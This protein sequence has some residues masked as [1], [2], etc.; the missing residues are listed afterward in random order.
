MHSLPRQ[1]IV[2][3]FL[4]FFAAAAVAAESTPTPTQLPRL[5]R[6]THYN[7]TIEPDAA[8]LTF[9]GDVAISLEVLAP[10][11]SITLNA[12]DMKFAIGSF[13]RQH[14][15]SAVASE[16]KIT[17]DEAA[18]TAT[19]AFDKK[20]PS[21]SYWL[22][23]DYTGKIGTQAV[24]L[25]AIDYDT[26]DRQEARAVHAVRSVG[27]AP[28]DPVLG[29]AGLQGDVRARSD[30]AAGPDG[31]QQ[32][33][34]RGAHRHGR[35]PR[36][37]ALRSR[38]RRCRPTC[39]S[40]G[41]AN[42]I[43]RPRS[44]D[45][46]E[47]GVVTQKGKARPGAVRARFAPCSVLREYNDYFGMPYPLPKLDNIA[48]PGSSQFFG[49]M[50]NWG[51]IFTFEYAMLLDPAISTQADKQGVFGIAAHE[52][53]HQ[54]FGDLVTMRWWDDLWLNEGFASWM[55]S[56]TTQRLHP[57]W[58]AELQRREL[59]RA[60][61]AIATR[62]R[63]P[64]R[65]CSRVETVEQAAQAFD[66]ISYS[67]G[68]AVMH[69]LE[70]YVGDD[71]WR[72][73]VRRYMKAHAYGNTVSDDL[74]REVEAAA[75]QPITAIAHDFTL[76]PGVPLIRVASATCQSGQTTLQ[77]AQGEFSKRPAEQEAAGVAR[78]RH[79]RSR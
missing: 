71:A 9:R 72:E 46:T 76:Q 57:E 28:H 41:S 4:A 53:A 49:A 78:A 48:S 30:R 7:V 32:H 3:T 56:R 38:R 27:C 74:W 60:G 68:Q 36:A 69:M 50:E 26:A 59:A 54:W 39:C 67:K 75:G 21:G 25:F 43:A 64:T 66:A 18:Q 70:G 1:A 33:A 8:A 55:A 12:L 13:H 24:G 23:L 40:S 19:F 42:S 14:R 51:A 37:R 47:L 22:A 58:H 34:G 15:Q 52:I 5:V 62:S 17:V 79:W 77:L 2:L 6:P 73:G 29:R 61:D 11:Q 63:P 35:R 65:S 20:I 10:V 31:R 44:S 16:P 45:A